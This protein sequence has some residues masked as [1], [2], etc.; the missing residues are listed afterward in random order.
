VPGVV[1]VPIIA[2]W[3]VAFVFAFLMFAWF[4]R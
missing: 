2:V 1:A 3:A 4:Y